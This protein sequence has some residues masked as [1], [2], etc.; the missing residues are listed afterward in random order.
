[1]DELSRLEQEAKAI[2][3]VRVKGEL[4]EV[5]RKIEEIRRSIQSV[6]NEKEVSKCNLKI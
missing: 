6:Q 5:I 4:E 3:I 2:D 1:M